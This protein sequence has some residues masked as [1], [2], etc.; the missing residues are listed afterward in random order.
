M[1]RV[2]PNRELL[3]IV[4]FAASLGVPPDVLIQAAG[5][6]SVIATNADVSHAQ[7]LRLWEEA[8]RLS[9]DP[10]FGLHLAEWLSQQAEDRFDVL[11]YAMRSCA[12]L[13][14]QYRRM[15]RYVRLI[16]KETFLSLEVDGETARMVHGVVGHHSSLRQP[17]EAMLA[18]IL[19]QGR[20]TLGEDFA[21]RE[22]CFEHP[23][24]A[25]TTEHARLF[26]APV[27]YGGPR[28]ELVF[29]RALLDRPQPHAEPRL[30]AMLE[31]HLEVLLSEIP[32]DRSVTGMV[33]RCVADGLLEGEPTLFSVA[34]KLRLSPRT[35]QRRLRDEGSNFADLLADVRHER[36]LHHLRN[37][38][39]SIQEVAFVLGFSD[40]T[41]F[42]R[43]F[44]RRTG[45]TPAEYR[46][47][48]TVSPARHGAAR[49]RET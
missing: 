40:V 46:R 29:E 6:D 27:H 48:G 7:V 25:R 18:L 47:S 23:E 35:L 39:L 42:H 28:D 44:K 17:S 14:E 32:E 8:T 26:R 30:Q 12:T 37:A 34:K 43:A 41:T 24:P 11:A 4:G 16:H 31:R 10:D 13:G 38:E 49:V 5:L 45:V 22:V 1:E 2:A 21:P 19:L 15:G 9:G 36:A 3:A 33:R 20:R